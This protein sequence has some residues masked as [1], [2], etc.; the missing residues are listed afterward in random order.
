MQDGKLILLRHGQST[1]N[2]EKR[3]TGWQDVPLTDKGKEDARL[4]GIQLNKYT[5]DTVFTST[6][7]RA[8]ETGDIVMSQ[9][10]SKNIPVIR[11]SALNERCYGLLEGRTHAEVIAET[12]EKQV[13]KWRRSFKE[14]PPDGESLSDTYGR[15]IPYFVE[16]IVPLFAER[17]TVLVVA[18][19]NS[20]R[21]ILIYLNNFNEEQVEQLT[22]PTA[23][24]I[25]YDVP[26]PPPPSLINE[27][28][29][30]YL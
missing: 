17:K 23:T 24:P 28:Y 9:L 21:A 6:L 8:I 20:L 27:R 15:V 18:H 11:N 29:A 10:D 25:V 14:C 2:A 1:W 5:I 7:T 19:G 4:V 26:P 13:H 30:K 22:V 3:F 12:S 16:H